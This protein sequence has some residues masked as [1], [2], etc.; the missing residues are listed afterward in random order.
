MDNNLSTNYPLL[1]YGDKNEEVEKLQI[2]LKRKGLFEG[3]IN[4]IYSDETLKAVISLKVNLK[5]R[6]NSVVSRGV[7]K[8]L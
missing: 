4:G 8:A 1:I 2:L 7:W 6:D 5:M 3:V